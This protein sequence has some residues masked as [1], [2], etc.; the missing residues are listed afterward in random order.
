MSHIV[1]DY[2]NLRSQAEV[3]SFWTRINYKLQIH[4]QKAP[5]AFVLIEDTSIWRKLCV[6]RLGKG[7]QLF[8]LLAHHPVTLS[9]W[10]GAQKPSLSYTLETQLAS[11]LVLTNEMRP[12]GR[13]MARVSCPL[14]TSL[15]R[16]GLAW[17]LCPM[18]ESI[19]WDSIRLPPDIQ[20]APCAQ[21]PLNLDVGSLGTLAAGQRHLANAW[22]LER[23]QGLPP[24]TDRFLQQ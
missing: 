19:S 23:I 15:S 4:S 9:L 1:K 24:R 22:K 5:R 7:L 3:T 11:G 2:L 6:W 10:T 20:L 21:L 12:V 14:R 16:P 8:C 18:L 17:L 13:L